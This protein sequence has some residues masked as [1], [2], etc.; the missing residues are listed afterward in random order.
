M[1]EIEISLN[2]NF[3]DVTTDNYKIVS[4]A[5]GIYN[6]C[7]ILIDKKLEVKIT[8]NSITI[9]NSNICPFVIKKNSNVNLI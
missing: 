7:Q 5:W 4:K 9:D 8:L 6:E 2:D 3:I 1:E